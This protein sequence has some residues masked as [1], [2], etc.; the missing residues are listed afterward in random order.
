MGVSME[1]IDKIYIKLELEKDP[2]AKDIYL[3]INFDKN[4]PNFFTDNNQ[5]RWRPTPKEIVFFNE[6]LTMFSPQGKP[7]HSFE[8]EDISASTTEHTSGDTVLLEEEQDVVDKVLKRK[9]P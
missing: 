4:A 2:N 1:K 8:N 6:A 3:T 5:I 7:H 9:K